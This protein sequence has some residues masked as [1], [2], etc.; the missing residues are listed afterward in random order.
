ML[1]TRLF[2]YAVALLAPSV[3]L[4][5]DTTGAKR[6]AVDIRQDIVYAKPGERELMTDLH[7][8]QG[9]KRPPLILFIHGGGW[10]NGNRKR[11][12]LAWVAKHGYAIAS[13]DYRLSQEAIFPAQIHDCKGALRWLRANQDQHGYDA[14]KVVVARTSAGGHLAA[15][16]ATS[17]DVKELEGN[18]GGNPDQSSRV[19][20][21]LDYYGPT[22]FILRS[23]HQPSKTDDPKGSVLQLL[24]GPVRENPEIARLASPSVHVSE[25]DPP[26]LIL[27]GQNDKTVYLRQS[28]HLK[29]LYDMNRLDATL[30]IESDKGHGWSKPTEAE[31]KAVLTFLNKHLN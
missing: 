20:G 21:A 19:Q 2:L 29:W 1:T 9:V 18:T 23:Y 31:K 13:I 17:G 5:A 7:M 25:D 28:E 22:D 26:L 16:M 8:P 12:K 24:G 6:H 30:H 14:S 3:F 27:H 15:M 10:K 4:A 11:C